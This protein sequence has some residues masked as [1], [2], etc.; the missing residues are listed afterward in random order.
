MKKEI[1]IKN[2][3]LLEYNPR[4]ND[5]FKF[6]KGQDTY[7]NIWHFI[8]SEGN[9][10][11]QIDIAVDLFKYEEDF[12][13]FII[14]VKSITTR[15]FNSDLDRLIIIQ[16]KE[17]DNL[18]AEGNRRLLAMKILLEEG[19]FIR[20]TSIIMDLYKEDSPVEL[21]YT[22]EEDIDYDDKNN[23]T[24]TFPMSEI[25][26]EIGTKKDE[27][28]LMHYKKLISA[29]GECWDDL[30]ETPTITL[31]EKIEVIYYEEG[32][33]FSF[34]RDGN[35]ID[36]VV[37][38]RSFPAPGGKR[39]WP[40]FQTLLNIFK[41]FEYS[42]GRETNQNSNLNYNQAI[43][44]TANKFAR[45]ENYI[46]TEL[47]SAKLIMIIK[48]N[49]NGDKMNS[50]VDWKKLKTTA[51][52]QSLTNINLDF[53]QELPNNSNF[54]NV[55][56]IKWDSKNST[57]E[58]S[59]F[60]IL[61]IDR[62]INKGDFI[63]EFSTFLVDE[64]LE[65]KYTT[66]GWKEGANKENIYHL[67]GYYLPDSGKT[68]NE[69]LGSWDENEV[70]YAI[71]IREVLTSLNKQTINLF[72]N[73]PKN[74]TNT[75]SVLL[76]N[77][78]RR[79]ILN[80]VNN[81]FKNYESLVLEEFPYFTIGSI[82]RNIYEL[83][84]LFLI[85]NSK[86]LREYMYNKSEKVRNIKRVDTFLKKNE[87][88]MENDEFDKNIFKLLNEDNDHCTR[89][90]K[91]ITSGEKGFLQRKI[92]NSSIDILGNKDIVITLK[93]IKDVYDNNLFNEV[94]HSPFVFLLTKNEKNISIIVNK[95][96]KLIELFVDLV[97]IDSIQKIKD[98]KEM[99]YD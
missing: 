60:N 17:K 76:L 95:S 66:R 63:K 43:K 31:K 20:L 69:M 48:K 11:N 91:D 16:T 29:V 51:I 38:Q 6:I 24:I 83:S 82:A 3:N 57:L 59:E 74:E 99:T 1:S 92:I 35:K 2:L 80:E 42:L 13:D 64:Y 7:K 22:Q 40:R 9:S 90:F 45:S 96:L 10:K 72:K 52:E 47:Y 30:S 65:R 58:F 15:G 33:E 26:E 19:F 8:Y 86:E 56:G 50:I 12:E 81:L 73:L 62:K 53:F 70:K 94:V 5:L 77:Y 49:Y 93:E 78:G 89:F 23:G 32:V 28:F 87:I 97:G 68:I 41:F 79:V 85:S 36:D 98:L 46:K 34:E 39:K 37:I 18:V 75:F 55:L 44:K 4:S 67:F 25:G 71:E 88:F 21:L 84:I 27:S 54:K 61:K 14:L